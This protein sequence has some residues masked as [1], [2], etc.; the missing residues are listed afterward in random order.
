MISAE[1]SR[2]LATAMAREPLL[3]DPER[4]EIQD[5]VRRVDWQAWSDVPAWLARMVTRAEQG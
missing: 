2:R 1:V 3:T 4:A 5:L